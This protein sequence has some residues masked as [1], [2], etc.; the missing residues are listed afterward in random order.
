[1]L[2][3]NRSCI[4][5]GVFIADA[6]STRQT[7]LLI[8]RGVTPNL[9]RSLGSP[10]KIDCLIQSLIGPGELRSCVVQ[11]YPRWLDGWLPGFLV[12]IFFPSSPR[13]ECDRL[14]RR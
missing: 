12:S 9:A 1:M 5:E 4:G 8:I 7:G 14:G 3:A 10:V 2:S 11:R 6:K 13:V